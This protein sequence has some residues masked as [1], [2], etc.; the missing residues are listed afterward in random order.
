MVEPIEERILGRTSLEDVVV[1]VKRA[2]GSEEEKTIIKEG[3]LITLEQSKL[4][5]NMVWNLYASAPY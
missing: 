4:V 3:D 2:D 1:K 5:K